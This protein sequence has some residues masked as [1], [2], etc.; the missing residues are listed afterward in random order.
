M[1]VSLIK[2]LNHQF[3]IFNSPNDTNLNKYIREI[4]FLNDTLNHTNKT[5]FPITTWVNACT[6]CYSH[7][8]LINAG[9]EIYDLTFPD[10][11]VPS[12]E[13]LNKWYNILKKHKNETIAVHCVAGLGRA[14]LLVAIGLIQ[15]GTTPLEAIQQIRNTR[16]AALNMPQIKFLKGYRPI[17]Y[18]ICLLL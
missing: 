9:F 8:T 16:P 2:S 14:P 13:I 10:G 1:E 4:K 18:A 12:T 15:D 3:V 6:P 11:S 5:K 7:E 17:R